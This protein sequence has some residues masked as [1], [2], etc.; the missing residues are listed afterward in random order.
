MK[1]I[2]FITDLLEV[3]VMGI[4]TLSFISGV[5]INVFE[6]AVVFFLFIISSKIK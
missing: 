4:I 5:M 6:F 1:V 3:G 2:K